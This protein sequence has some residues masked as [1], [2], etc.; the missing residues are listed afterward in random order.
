M[1]AT[2]HILVASPDLASRRALV[3]VINEEGHSTITVSRVRDCQDLLQTHDIRMIFCD[4]RLADGTYRDV[5][6]AA[7]TS[8]HQVPVVVNSRLAGWE[9]YREV[10]REGAWDL[11]AC[12]CHPADVLRILGQVN[13]DENLDPG[14]VAEP[15]LSTEIGA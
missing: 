7:R 13:G 9:E 4:R 6:A 15:R 1:N 5:L 11:I 2:G 3:A 8:K 10:L 12:P 14:S